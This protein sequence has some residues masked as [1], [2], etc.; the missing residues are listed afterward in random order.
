MEWNRVNVGMYTWTPWIPGATYVSF[1]HLP[2]LLCLTHNIYTQ[3]FSILFCWWRRPQLKCPDQPFQL[4]CCSTS[5][6][7]QCTH[8]LL[9]HL[10]YA[11]LSSSLQSCIASLNPQWP[12]WFTIMIS[13]FHSNAS[14]GPFRMLPKRTCKTNVS[15]ATS[16]VWDNITFRSVSVPFKR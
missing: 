10:F 12:R 13:R 3:H 8:P 16:T 9:L 15:T 14:P 4:L 1:L 7:S 2:L 6:K 11:A 5:L